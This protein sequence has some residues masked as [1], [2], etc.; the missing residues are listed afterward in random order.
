MHSLSKSQARLVFGKTASMHMQDARSHS[1]SGSTDVWHI[2]WL[3]HIAPGESACW[4][5]FKVVL[6]KKE[7]QLLW[8]MGHS[9]SMEQ[10]NVW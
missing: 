6:Q 8:S 2:A 3:K 9:S 10:V 7:E 1:Y 4:H 5:T